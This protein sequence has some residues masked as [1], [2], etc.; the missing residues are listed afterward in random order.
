M[1]KEILRLSIPSILA[2]ITVPLVGIVDVAI[3]GHVSDAAAIGGIAIGGMLFSLLY[4]NFGFLR[5]GTGG[6]T[7]QAYGRGDRQGMM[8]IFTQGMSLVLAAT[9][10]VW[11]IAWPF[12]E[13]VM[14]LVPCS[15]E[16]ETF[17]RQY[18]FIRIWAA[19]AVFALMCFKG[20]FI[21]MQ[22]TVWPMVC[23]IV[24]NVVNMGVSYYFAVHTDMGAIGVAYGT[25]VAQYTGLLVAVVLFVLKYKNLLLYINIRNSIKFEKLKEMLKLNGNLMLRSLGFMVVYV[26]CTSMAS[27]YGD[28]LLAVSSILMNLFMVFSYFI[29]GFAYAGEALVGRFIG[30]QNRK[31]VDAAVRL[32]FMWSMG[33][34]LVFTIVYWLWGEETVRMITSDET[35]IHD[36]LPYLLWLVLMPIVSC[37]AFIWDGIFIGA[38]AGRQV[39]DCMLW[40]ALGFVVAYV[41]TYKFCGFHAIYIAYFTHLVVRSGYLT[42]VWNRLIAKKIV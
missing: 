17:A 38:T 35:V 1:N 37:A 10:L 2:N 8:D 21:G 30:E 32:L 26:G 14:M 3:A 16:V 29:D 18:F 9:L 7:A 23:D 33:I 27:S 31:K 41:C 5:V 4:W 36:S 6:M 28:A 39:R 24:V 13:V 42:A 12:L 11:L 22:N 15:Q 20:W 34:G 25:V 40:A 19:P